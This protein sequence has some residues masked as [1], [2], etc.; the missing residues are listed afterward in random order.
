MK[1]A[2]YARYGP[3]DVIQIKEIETPVP[4][5]NEVLIKVHAASVNPYDWHFLRGTPYPLR[6]AAGLRTPKIPRLGADVA[7]RVET[8]GKNVTQFKPGDA[9]FGMARGAFAEYVCA[10]EAKLC[11]KPDGVTFE[12]AACVPIAGYTALQGLRDKG[13]IQAGQEVMINGAS[14]GVGTFAVQL[15][16]SFG[17]HVTGV[18]STR[19][20]DL[21]RSIG[22]DHVMDYTVE[23][24][25]KGAQRYDLLLDCIGNH[26]LSACRRVLTSLGT[27]LIIGG[28][29]SPWMIGFA[30]RLIKALVLSRFVRQNL[31]FVGAKSSQR[32]LATM[33]ELMAA[34]KVTPVIDRRYP[35]KELPGAIRYSEAGHARGKIIITLE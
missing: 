9:V 8:I 5:D 10:D 25:T 28:P 35:L 34:G 26:S 4:A 24:F 33:G 2:V 31:V 11:K 14:G 21:I 18:C 12:Q 19:N 20:L 1:A 30:G 15:A 29:S 22:A 13:N 16:K 23:D 7:G 17:A 6:L 32:D 3:P 27:C